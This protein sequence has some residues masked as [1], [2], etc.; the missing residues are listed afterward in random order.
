MIAKELI[1]HSILPVKTSDTGEQVL[2]RMQIYHVSHLPIVNNEKILGIISE[3]DILIHDPTE[4]I[5]A[6][7]LQHQQ[8]YCSERDHIFDLMTKIGTFKLTL[9]PVI[10]TDNEVYIGVITLEDVLKYFAVQFS[11]TDPGS[12]LVIETS[13][14]NYLLSEIIRLAEGEDITVLSSFTTSMPDS[15]KVF[16]TLKLNAQDIHTYK[17]SLERFGYEIYATFSDGGFGD[18]LQERY[19]SLMSY[20]NI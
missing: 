3:D 4:S 11:F 18:T 15:N 16:I 10:D 20:L 2:E 8:I 17:A 6:Y 13:G 19:D 1:S 7:R 9:L 12:I 5:G 14:R